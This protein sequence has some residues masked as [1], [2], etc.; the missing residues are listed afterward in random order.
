M[1]ELSE[2]GRPRVLILGGGFAGIGAVRKLKDAE[3]DVVLVDRHDYHTFQPL[4]Y[5]LATGL[6]ERTAVGHPLRDLVHGQENAT[7]H[8][9]TVTGA[10]SRRARGPVRGAGADHLRLP[11]A[12]AR[13]RGQLLRR[14]GAAEHAFPMYTLAD[15]V[16]LKDHVLQQVG[17]RPTGT[18]RSSTTAR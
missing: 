11:G 2:D 13:R 6:L 7:V 17:G 16:R 14:R 8:Q 10:R 12:R 3:V 4:L 9:A 1:A 18:R 5:Q 15:A